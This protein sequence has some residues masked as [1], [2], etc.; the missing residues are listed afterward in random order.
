MD[1]GHVGRRG[2]TSAC[3]EQTSARRTSTCLSGDHLRVCGADVY[4]EAVG[5]DQRG[6]P[7]RVRSRLD[8]EVD[9][10]PM[11]R[12][13]SACA[14]QTATSGTCG[15]AWR[16]HLRVCGADVHKLL[17]D[18]IESGSPP[19]V[20]S[21]RT[22]Y[23]E[24]EDVAGI[25]SA[26]A[27]QTRSPVRRRGSG[28]DHLRVC[29][30]DDY[31]PNGLVLTV[32]SPPRVRSRRHHPRLWYRRQGITS[33]CAEQTRAVRWRWRSSADHLRVCGADLMTANGGSATGGSPPRVRSRQP[34]VLGHGRG[35]GITSACAEQTPSSAAR[36]NAA[37]DHLR[38]CGA[39]RHSAAVAPTLPGSPPRVRSRQLGGFAEGQRPGITS[40]CAEQT[41]TTFATF[42]RSR[43]HLRVCGADVEFSVGF[44]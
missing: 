7:P 5:V 12:I 15:G 2:I 24:L 30:A 10:L 29:G 9:G 38:V 23:D 11:D 18:T 37:W 8:V 40:A 35:R 41:L 1:Y 19:R 31:N 39:D 3:A 22:H 16:D 14:E 32:G 4:R 44:A 27:E 21:R 33:A 17:A 20:R 34:G 6:S 42:I 43:D 25:T 28:R 36:S 26:C 13:T